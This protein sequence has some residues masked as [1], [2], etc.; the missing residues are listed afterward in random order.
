MR[1]ALDIVSAVEPCFDILSLI[2]G[3]FDSSREKPA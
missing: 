1:S 3:R 2:S